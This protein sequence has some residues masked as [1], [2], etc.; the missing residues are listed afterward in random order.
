MLQQIWIIHFT[1]TQLSHFVKPDIDK[2]AKEGS[3][4]LISASEL[5]TNIDPEST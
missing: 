3:T 1:S 5:K 4:Q 2:L